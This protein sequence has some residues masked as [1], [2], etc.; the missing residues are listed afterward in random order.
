MTT[1][2]L[3]M[4]IYQDCAGILADIAKT[5][6]SLDK[7]DLAN[8]AQRFAD[9]LILTYSESALKLNKQLKAEK[10]QVFIYRILSAL[11]APLKPIRNLK[12]KA[13]LIKPF[14]SYKRALSS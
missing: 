10:A 12:R 8:L 14:Q 5:Y 13:A 3:R 6:Q 2:E 9:D 4:R 11:N 7:I 1:A